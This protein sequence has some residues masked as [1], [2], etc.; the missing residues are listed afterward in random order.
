MTCPHFNWKTCVTSPFITDWRFSDTSMSCTTIYSY[1]TESTGLDHCMPEMLIW[2]YELW[3]AGLCSAKGHRVQFFCV[4][5]HVLFSSQ[6]F[7]LF[8]ALQ[9]PV[10]ITLFLWL[11]FFFFPGSMGTVSLCCIFSLHFFAATHCTAL[12]NKVY[13]S[14]FPH[15]N[16][17][18]FGYSSCSVWAPGAVKA[19]WS[20][21]SSRVMN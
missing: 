5:R 11:L 8:L 12:I 7:K 18:F 19:D 20:S 14:Q 9:G 6:V 3:T 17:L 4:V 21:N 10:S 13:N 16:T 15:Q 2:E 1:Y